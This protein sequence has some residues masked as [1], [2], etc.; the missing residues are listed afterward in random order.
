MVGLSFIWDQTYYYLRISFLVAGTTVGITRAL[1]ECRAQSTRVRR[2]KFA[3][4]P[5]ETVTP[6]LVT[7]KPTL[8]EYGASPYSSASTQS[9]LVLQ[10]HKSQ[11]VSTQDSMPRYEMLEKY[12]ISVLESVYFGHL[13]DKEGAAVSGESL[14]NCGDIPRKDKETDILESVYFDHLRQKKHYL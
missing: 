14:N 7:V 1:V 2:P 8:P 10:A 5:H 6:T 13:V 3:S 11:G 4:K 12:D 9:A